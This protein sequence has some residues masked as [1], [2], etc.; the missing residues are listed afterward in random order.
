MSTA[1]ILP[2]PG[3]AGERFDFVTRLPF[4]TIGVRVFD[5]SIGQIAFLPDEAPE[6]PATGPVAQRA[7]HQL[8]AYC[9]DSSH[10]IEFPLAIRGTGFQRRVWR[11]I[12]MIPAGATRTYGELADRLGSAP[13]AVGQACGSNP[14]PLVIPCHRVVAARGIGG[15]AHQRGGAYER[16]KRW[17]LR[18]ECGVELFLA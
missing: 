2:A 1:A 16:I 13:R 10:R 18:H 14:L 15:F 4:G 17:L 7:V 12:A 8:L 6:K 5:R 3:A 9:D 11:E